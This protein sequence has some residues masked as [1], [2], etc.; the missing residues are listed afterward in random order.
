M[1]FCTPARIYPHMLFE[2][3]LLAVCTFA[4]AGWAGSS[5]AVSGPVTGFIF[6]AQADAVRPMRGIPGAAYLDAPVVN[7][8]G[9]ASVAPDGSAVLVVEKRAGRLLLY[10]GLRS[11]TP[12]PVTIRGA[13]AG[14]DHFAWSGGSAA[15]VY[16]SSSGQAQILTNLAQSPS[17]GAPVSL[18]GLPGPV[19]ALAF[20]GQRMIL[21]VSGDSGGIYL[22]GQTAAAQRIAAA[23]DPS[24]I[25]AAGADLYFADRQAQQIWQVESYA[26]APAAVLF[27]ND[28]GISSPAGMQLSADGQRLYVANAGNRKLEIYNIATRSAAQSLDLSFTP[29][30]LD[31]FGDTSVFLLNSSGPGPFYVLSDGNPAKIAVYFVPAGITHRTRPLHPRPI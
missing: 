13:I 17:A 9:A 15:A 23:T 2:R 21:G 28:S 10:T 19:T 31:G 14:A 12:T 16:A 26:G 22:A 8:V 18:A 29:T 3:L 30:R 4:A 6:D 1:R 24:A 20:D 11:G 7:G 27:A 5:T 25:V